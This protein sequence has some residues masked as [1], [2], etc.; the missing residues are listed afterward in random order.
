MFQLYFDTGESYL[1]GYH[2][3]FKRHEREI[4]IGILTDY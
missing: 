2:S 1:G 3:I 4:E